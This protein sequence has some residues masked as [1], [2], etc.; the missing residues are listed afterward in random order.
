MWNFSHKIDFK[1]VEVV[2]Y[3]SCNFFITQ[4]SNTETRLQ[5]TICRWLVNGTRNKTNTLHHR[6]QWLEVG[7][8]VEST[9]EELQGCRSPDDLPAAPDAND[10][11]LLPEPSIPFVS[12]ITALFLALWSFLLS[13]ILWLCWPSM[14]VH[15]PEYL[16]M[17]FFSGFLSAWT[18]HLPRFTSILLPF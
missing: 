14:E 13:A 8:K 1:T 12:Y 2:C 5:K 7:L 4:M 17:I 18:S 15:A 6:V 10:H 11:A 16:L 3:A 9:T